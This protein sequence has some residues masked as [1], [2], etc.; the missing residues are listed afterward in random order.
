MSDY[1]IVHN[2]TM[3]KKVKI[4][5]QCDYVLFKTRCV[6]GAQGMTIDPQSC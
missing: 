4:G 1:E 2:V 6:R 5:C 3:V